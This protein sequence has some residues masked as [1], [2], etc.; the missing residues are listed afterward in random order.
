[1]ADANADALARAVESLLQDPA[2][3]RMLGEAARRRATEMFSA[4]AI[5]PHYEALYA[6]V[7]AERPAPVLH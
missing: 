6:R 7:V 4:A 1:V 5:V 2:R 3:R